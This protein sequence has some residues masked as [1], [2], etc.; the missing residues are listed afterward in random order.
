MNEK[1]LSSYFRKYL[2]T[3]NLDFLE[4]VP[5]RKKRIDFV[6]V[7]DDNINT[8]E[9]KVSDWKTVIH[10]AG[11]N[12]LFSNKSYIV[13]WHKFKNRIDMELIKKYNIGLYLIQKNKVL[14][15]YSPHNNNKYIKPNYY[16]SF[17]DKIMN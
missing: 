11:Q 15:I 9:L 17:K 1:L 5:F 13:F 6:I 8:F 2:I 14:L 10:Q 12:L 16:K 7:D 3:N 4:Q